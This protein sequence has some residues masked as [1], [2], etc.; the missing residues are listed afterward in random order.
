[1]LTVW[2][3]HIYVVAVALHAESGQQNMR[4]PTELTAP[5]LAPCEQDILVINLHPLSIFLMDFIY[6]VL[7]LL[8]ILH[9]SVELILIGDC[10]TK[11]VLSNSAYNQPPLML[12]SIF[13]YINAKAFP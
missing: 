4:F 12:V 1:M 10:L 8:K 7:L 13:L 3:L 2:V 9:L 11:A 6:D 5:L